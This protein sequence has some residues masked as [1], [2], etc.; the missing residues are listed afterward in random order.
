MRVSAWIR[1]LP[2]HASRYQSD[3]STIINLTSFTPEVP[4]SPPSMRV[5]AGIRLLPGHAS[6]Y[7]SGESPIINLTSFAPEVPLSLVRM[8]VVAITYLLA[9]HASRYQFVEST[10]INLTSFAPEASLSPVAVRVVAIIQLLLWSRQS[11]S[12]WRVSHY[13]SDEFCSGGFA[14]PSSSKGCSHNPTATL[15]TPVIINLASLP[16]SI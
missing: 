8:R 9:G 1:L 10:I 3:E 7:Q 2:G 4:L 6:R 11:L 14:E 16:L 5:S 13:Q 15:V 12:I